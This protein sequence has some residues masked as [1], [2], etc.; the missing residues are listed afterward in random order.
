M[1][2]LHR[3]SFALI[4]LSATLANGAEKL[5]AS[6]PSVTGNMAPLWLAQDQRLFEK[7]G[8]D[9]T[10]VN[11]SS[12]FVS[13]NALISGDI[14]IAAASSSSAISSALR[15]APVT[16]VATF[17]PT[18]YKLVANPAINSLQALK[19]KT[20]GTS[21]P[22]SGSD[23]ALRRFLAKAGLVPGKDIAILPT[24]LS[25]SD[26]RVL[27]MLQGKMDATLATADTIA[28]FE[29][30]GQKVNVLADL[31]AMGI[32]T[33]GSVVAMTRDFLQRRRPQAK[34]FLLAFC[35]G[36]AMAKRNKESAFQI[37]RKHLR[38]QEPK[39][40]EVIYRTSILDRL[41]SK[42]YPEEEAVMFDLE[43]LA[44]NNADLREKIAASKPAQ[45]ADSSLLKEMETEGFFAALAR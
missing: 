16:I 15:G 32:H 30:K 10:L 7:H 21:R 4:F 5:T 9:L 6:Y 43:L 20:I 33:S 19:G 3:L 12:G 25:E 29:M 45:F 42:P 38:V 35:E 39:L 24:G 8:L 40:L 17:G 11:I 41:P 26:K 13:I 37:Y 34:A 1:N 18:P 27:S 2:F 31:L 44:A 28:N 22:G 36:I 14:Q 23:F